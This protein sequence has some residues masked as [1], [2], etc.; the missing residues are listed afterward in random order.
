LR[1]WA[2][3]SAYDSS[4]ERP[5]AMQ[6]LITDYNYNHNRPHSTLGGRPP[7]ARLNNVLGF[8]T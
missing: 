1:E 7:A 2:Y 5:F 3:A 6:P 8:D 4:A